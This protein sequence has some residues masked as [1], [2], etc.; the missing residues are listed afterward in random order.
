M[1]FS[2]SFLGA[3]ENVTGSRYLLEA[4]GLRI[5]VDCGLYQEWHLKERNWDSFPIPPSSIHAVLLTHAHLDHCGWLPRLVRGGFRGPVYATAATAEIARIVLLDAAHLQE[6]DAAFKQKRHRREGR[7]PARPVVPL[8]TV[9]DAEESLPLFKPVS[10]EEN[11]QVGDGVSVT[12]HDAGHIL[13]SS[14]L[15]VKLRDGGEERVVLFSGDVG[16]RDVPI[17]RDP[18]VFG[19]ADYILCESTY[20]DRVHEK[21]ED[22]NGLLADIINSTHRAGG[23]IVVPSFS[24]ERAQE[25]LYHLNEL[26]LANRIPHLVTFLD[27]PMAIRVTEVFERHPE[28]FDKEMTELMQQQNSPFDFAGLQM[29]RTTDQSKAINHIKGTA[30]I[31][32]GSGMCTGGRVKHH[33]VNNIGRGESTVLFVGYQAMG[34]LGRQ[35]AEGKKEV[36]ILG[37]THAVKARVAQLHGF[38]G[39]ADRNE[40]L[41][42]LSG[43]K[44]G[45]RRLFA[46]HGEANA[47]GAFAELVADKLGWETSVAKY[48]QKVAL[49]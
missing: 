35:I 23:N 22:T 18:T 19:Q 48:R 10:Y 5:L 44:K 12:F 8:Y 3:A 32:S 30:L 6:E 41:R 38:S 9:A 27:S 2:L 45:R 29:T 39:H 37:E 13:G 33:L 21:A 14:M 36:S 24:V 31:I 28:L 40:L 11:V 49:D 46:T 26:L 43:I 1:K 16:R 42:W 25:V 34:T 4:N 15:E 47:A 7:T 17:L 20:G